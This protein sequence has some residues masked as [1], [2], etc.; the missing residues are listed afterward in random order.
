MNFITAETL[1][2]GEIRLENYL[3]DIGI[4]NVRDEILTGL[5]AE[6]K[7]I[8]SKFFYDEK[9]SELFEQITQL[10]EYYP[11]R[12]EK[13]ILKNIGKLMNISWD[14]LQ[15]IELGSGDHSKISLFLEQVPARSRS[16]MKYYP[17]DISES[18]IEQAADKLTVKF[19]ELSIHGV[20]ADFIR[21]LDVLPSNGRR[22]FCFFG[23]TIGN[24]TEDEARFFLQSLGSIMNQGDGLLMGMDM[25]KNLAT[26]NAAYND[27]EN[28]TAQ[29]N[30]N[31]LN[32][33]NRLVGSNFSTSD[34]EHQAFFN[35][36]K[37]RIEMHL[38][39]LNSIK[40]FINGLDDP[41]HIA[42]GETIHTENSHK[43]NIKSIMRM[44]EW[45]Q[46]TSEEVFTDSRNW[47]T[48]AYFI[49]K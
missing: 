3:P 5:L 15:L 10:K 43:Y 6:K 30:K 33:V 40:I 23:S 22:L 45:A 27:A 12:T 48:L 24:L 47:F 18:A 11:T 2:R 49:K 44:A 19:P 32:V 13:S 46:L 8:S 14:G 9:G 35:P 28:I 20:V 26:L 7:Y 16:T 42:K 41:I 29:F 37:K 4:K 34:F 31:I 39:A 21:Q 38:R 36:K 1:I 25:I 17:V